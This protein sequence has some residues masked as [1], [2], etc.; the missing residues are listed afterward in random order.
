MFAFIAR[1]IELLKMRKFCN[2]AKMAMFE[3]PKSQLIDALQKCL[4]PKKTDIDL[5]F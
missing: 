4:T 1:S 2:L 3:V 5:N